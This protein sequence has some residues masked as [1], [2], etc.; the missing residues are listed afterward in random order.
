MKNI[1]MIEYENLEKSNRP[2]FDEIES[3]VNTVIRK[4]FYILGSNVSEFEHEFAEYCGSGFCVG[5]ASG[6]DALVLALKS[7]DLPAGS[8]VLVP[9]NTYIATILAIVNSGHTPVLVEPDIKTYNIDPELIIPHITKKTAAILVVHL[10][11]KLCNMTSILAI[12]Q[13]YGLKTVE[14][15]AQAHGASFNGKKAGTWGDIGA[16]SF[17]PT[18]NL[19]GIGD[20]GAITTNDEK[21]AERIRRLRNYGSRVK[22]HF[23]EPGVNSRLDELQAAILRVKLKKLDQINAHK[24][25]LANLYFEKIHSKNIVKPYRSDGYFDVFHI[26]NIRCERRDELKSFLHTRGIN[27]DI[28]YPIPPHKQNALSSRFTGMNFPVSDEIHSTTLSLPISFGHTLSEIEKV[29]EALNSF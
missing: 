1:P 12:A 29:I 28:H 17:Y 10:Y 6:L 27:T 24:N 11:G 15:C 16:F 23:E 8:E 22:Y 2:F 14:D 25:N 26:Y 18:K 9:S 4:G 19:G 13:K 3:A 5:V 21:I 7:L 20:G